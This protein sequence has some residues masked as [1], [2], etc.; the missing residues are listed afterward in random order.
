MEKEVYE[1]REDSY[2]ILDQVRKYSRG[3]VLDMGTGSGIL[4]INASQKA[5]FVYG[6]DISQKAVN[7]ARKSAQGIKNIKFIKSDLF[8]Y[9]K[10]NPETFDLIIFNP[11]YLPEEKFEPEESRL[12]TTG[13][14]KGYELLE[15]FL[16]DASLYLKPDGKILIVFST[17]T[18][19][20]KVHEI[21]EKFGF[22]YHKLAE[23]SFF[24]ETIF[25]YL[26]EKSD[27]LL[28][29]EEE[30]IK[31]IKRFAKGHRGLIYTG[32]LKNKK[33]AVKRKNPESKA[34]G[35]MLNEA[36]WIK[37]LN[38]YNI[39]PKF[40]MQKDDYFVYYFVE[41]VFFPEFI[42][43]AGKTAIKKIINSVFEQCYQLDKLK[44][45]K[46]EM[47]HPYKHI[48]VAKNKP[49]LLDFERTH[50][51]GKPHNVTQFCQYII[52]SN[53]TDTLKKKGFK[54][55]KRKIMSLASRY[56][57]SMQEKD[58]LNILSSVK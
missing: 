48:V 16:Q 30:G 40:I 11:P 36:R 33:I 7:Y 43:K 47:H 35:R 34:V 32:K 5:E 15:R 46:E 20:N 18:K 21:I 57:K 6:L 3:K 38:K 14:K 52:S 42:K 9:F 27:F 24:F 58:F 31:N 8:N 12:A 49:A 41:G 13:G 4:A 50:K 45:S 10:K 44:I 56:K 28:S 19:Q 23:Q 54:I 39:G 26:L 37:F 17:L 53:I 22:N 2:L 51:T 55:D 1:P 29:V 25:V